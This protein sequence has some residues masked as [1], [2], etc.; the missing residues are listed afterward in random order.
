MANFVSSDKFFILWELYYIELLKQFK[1]LKIFNSF[2]FEIWF[3]TQIIKR[4]KPVELLH[5]I[6]KQFFKKKRQYH[7]SQF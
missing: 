1:P 2:T 6:Q 4:K 3:N 5:E 7:P